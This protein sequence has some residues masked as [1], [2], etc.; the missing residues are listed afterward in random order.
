MILNGK[1]GIEMH[2]ENLVTNFALLPRWIGG[3]LVWLKPY[4]MINHIEFMCIG[5]E[6]A[7]V[8]SN[9]LFRNK[10][11]AEEKLNQLSSH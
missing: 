4:Y 8:R 9:S 10:K 6:E 1:G 3:R 11:E 7:V 5:G 2:A